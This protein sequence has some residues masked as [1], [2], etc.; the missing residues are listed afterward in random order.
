MSKREWPK[1]PVMQCD[2][3]CSDCCGPAFC[4]THEFNRITQYAEQ[5]GVEPVRQG[6]TCPF[7]Q[8]GECRVYPVR[9]FVCR[10]FG[11]SSRLVCSKGYNTNIT[12]E[13]EERLHAE[14]RQRGGEPTHC[15]HELVYSTD[16]FIGLLTADFRESSAERQLERN[17]G[18]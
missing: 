13:Y 14:Y 10:L 5:H 16:E 18:R 1:L 3:E 11:H 9:P 12:P 4:Q 6:L 7:W 2:P 17:T 15:L 8:G